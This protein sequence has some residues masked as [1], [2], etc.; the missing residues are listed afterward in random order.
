MP[1]TAWIGVA[2]RSRAAGAAAASAGEGFVCAIMTGYP[3][4]LS[5]IDFFSGFRCADGGSPP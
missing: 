2:F 5:W 1:R 4:A 3:T